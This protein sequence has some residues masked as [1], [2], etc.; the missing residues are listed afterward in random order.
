MLIDKDETVLQYMPMTVEGKKSETSR[1]Y[2]AENYGEET[3][4][5]EEG[6]ISEDEWL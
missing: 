6:T 3:G 1:R 2:L 4:K 5:I